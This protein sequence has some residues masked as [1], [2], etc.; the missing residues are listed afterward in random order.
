MVVPPAV[1]E[2]LARAAAAHGA[3]PLEVPIVRAED[4]GEPG[5]LYALDEPWLWSHLAGDALAVP[6]PAALRGELAAFAGKPGAMA[7]LFDG[8]EP[9]R[10]AIQR[11]A[12]VLRPAAKRLLVVGDTAA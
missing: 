4:L 1:S 12:A 2:F 3:S 11:R 5:V 8:L 6:E 9:A 10:A 7:T